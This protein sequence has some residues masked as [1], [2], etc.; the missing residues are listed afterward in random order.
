MDSV[1][2]PVGTGV[3]DRDMYDTVGFGRGMLFKDK[4]QTPDVGGLR[5]PRACSSRVQIPRS[6]SPSE[7]HTTSASSDDVRALITELASQ[8]GQSIADQL[9][10]KSD[11]TAHDTSVKKGVSQPE[12]QPTEFNLSGVKLVMQSDAKEPPIY[13]GDSSDKCSVREWV[14]MVGAYFRKSNVPVHQQLQEILAKLRGKA[15]DVVRVTLRHNST[16][17]TP[18]FVYDILKQ[19]FSELTYSSMPMADFYN[20]RP[21]QNEGVMDYWIR[22]NNAIDI[23]DECL[24]RQKRSVEDPGREVCMMF[25][26]FCP[27]PILSNRLSFKAAEEWTTSEVQERIDAYQRELRMRT[28][29][30]SHTPLR[31]IVTH[32]Q[33]AMS[34]EPELS[35]P[36]P[37][38]PQFQLPFSQGFVLPP[39]NMLANT[40]VQTPTS[41]LSPLAEQFVPNSPAVQL[42]QPSHA[43]SVPQHAQSPACFQAPQSSHATP[44]TAAAV[45]VNSMNALISLLDHLVVRQNVQAPAQEPSY[46]PLA[47]QRRSCRVC[48]DVKHS[49][50]AHCRRENLCLA[51]FAPG[52]WK[53]N[54]DKYGR[55]RV[56]LDDARRGPP[57]GN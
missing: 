2:T 43:Q 22:L 47:F 11:V 4:V 38:E 3:Y 13:R 29:T 19:H 31:H 52:H 34:R 37:T 17:P 8:I 57:A 55:K 51:C 45:G 32:T 16:D 49:T 23:A 54:C 56:G 39:V 50:L 21:L 9:Q 40:S 44:A 1:N 30:S 33:S 25:I 10:R 6:L 5:T 41:Q 14:E 35:Q 28:L 46:A 7:Q 48:D 24:K 20:T 18:D 53:K 12:Q 36:A 15:G 42:S 27:D 26:K